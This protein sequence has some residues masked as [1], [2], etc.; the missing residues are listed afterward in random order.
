MHLYILRCID[1]NSHLIAFDA[2][3]V[4]VTPSP[5]INASPTRLVRINKCKSPKI[6]LTSGPRILS[7]TSQPIW[8]NF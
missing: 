5:A 7:H 3:T 1:P 8:L 4:T 2:I 6:L